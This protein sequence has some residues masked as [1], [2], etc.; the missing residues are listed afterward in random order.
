MRNLKEKLKHYTIQTL[1]WIW[2]VYASIAVGHLTAV[3]YTISL[4]NGYYKNTILGKEVILG[5][6]YYDY[7]V[8]RD[9][10]QLDSIVNKEII[11]RLEEG[12]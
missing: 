9:S 6:E 10:I 2:I 7:T 12:K 3:L 5:E 11:K 4:G 8:V 1:Y